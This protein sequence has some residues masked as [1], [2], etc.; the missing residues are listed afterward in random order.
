M[1]LMPGYKQTEVG[2]IPEDW[3]IV[4]LDSVA[5]RGSG[6]TP[7]KAY[8]EY[9][10]GQI[11]WISLQDSDR[12]DRLYIYDTVAKI[13]P[14]GIANSSAKMHPAGTVVLSRDAGVGKSAI[15]TNDMAVSQ[16]FM[17]WTCSAL[18]NNHY[19]YYW[20]QSNKSEFERI[21]MGNT[22]KTIGLPYFK[23]LVIQLPTLAEQ[24]AIAE[25][26]SDADALIEALAQLIAKKRQIKQGAMQE[27]LRPK[28]GWVGKRLDELASFHKG[29]GLAK[30][31]LHPFGMYPCIH[32][33]ELFTKYSETISNVQSCT[34]SASGMFHSISNDVLM[35]TS[36]VTPNGLATASCI[37]KDGVIL[38][39]DILVIRADRKELN[40]TFLSYIIRWSKEQVMQ[41]IKGTTVY[42]LHGSDMKQF[43]FTMPQVRDQEAIVKILSDMDAEIAA[44]EAKLAKA[45]QVKQGMMQELL[46][47][48]IRLI[49]GVET[50]DVASVRGSAAVYRRK[51]LRLYVGWRRCRDTRCCVCMWGGGGVETQYFASVRGSAAV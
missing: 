10:G 14:A 4:L 26:L 45:R 33:G 19:L 6:H 44:Q 47:G 34:N 41:L 28:N 3:E 8:P 16:H 7:D 42:H 21:A 31:E 38:G 23:R 20:L 5:K 12:L 9:W 40:G 22:I 35:P 30:S 48:R 39:G 36:D 27:L 37:L 43:S 50:Q 2:V 11:K 51:M 49:G 24:E 46:T 1:E 25:A 17:A 13:T 18:L 15:M 32:Y 29:K